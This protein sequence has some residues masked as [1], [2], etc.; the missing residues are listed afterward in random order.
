MTTA[1]VNKS[2]TNKTTNTWSFPVNFV[3]LQH[4]ALQSPF[5]KNRQYTAAAFSGGM[6]R[7]SHFTV[8]LQQHKTLS[9]LPD[10]QRQ[11]LETLHNIPA[12]R[13]EGRATLHNVPAGGRQGRATLHGIPAGGPHDCA[14]LH[15][16][17]AGQRQGCA[18]FRHSNTALYAT[19]KLSIN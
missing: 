11:A 3:H 4:T 13:R 18:T 16:A 14:T 1:A 12:H 8:S 5:K 6:A 19:C 7:L 15:S 17:A 9:L 2:D 10:M